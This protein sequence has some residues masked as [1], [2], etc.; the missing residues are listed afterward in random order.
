MPRVT[1][2]YGARFD[3]VNEYT[4]ATQLSPRVNVVWNATNTTTLHIGYARY[5]TPPPFELVG[6]SRSRQFNGTSGQALP[7]R[8]AR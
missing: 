3:G 5:F 6:G 8:T 1:I 4:S 2:N 7:P